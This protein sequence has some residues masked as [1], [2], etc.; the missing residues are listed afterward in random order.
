MEKRLIPYSVHL[1]EPIYHK[2]KE[3]AGNRQAA[4][5]VR[6]ALIAFCEGTP[7]YDKGYNSA[8][9]AITKRINNHKLANSLAFNGETV[10]DMIVRE[11]GQ[12]RK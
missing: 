2:I 3:F 11:I 9:E 7:L 8:I 1:P 5:V 4:G 12:L 6:D 10:A